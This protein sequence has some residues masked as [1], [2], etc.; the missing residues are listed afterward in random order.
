MTDVA[1]PEKNVTCEDEYGVKGE[2]ITLDKRYW[3]EH[4]RSQGENAGEPY[5]IPESG[6]LFIRFPPG[7]AGKRVRIYVE[8]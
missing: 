5:T 8:A 7:S 1:P 3:N 4:L 6:A 2:Y